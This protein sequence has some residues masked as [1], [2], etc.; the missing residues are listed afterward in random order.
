MKL[1]KIIAV[2]VGDVEYPKYQITIPK[3][4]IE[5]LAWEKGETLKAE[6]TENGLFICKSDGN[7]KPDNSI[8]YEEFEEEVKNIL[9]NEDHVHLTWDDIRK[10]AK[11]KIKVPNHTWVNRLKENIGLEIEYVGVKKVWRIAEFEEIFE[12]IND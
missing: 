7:G 12:P 8:T 11:F 6:I 1:Q 10:L 3:K 2:K 4:L 9:E 5:Q